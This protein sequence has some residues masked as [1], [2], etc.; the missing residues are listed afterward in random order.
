M[1]VHLYG[2]PLVDGKTVQLDH[3]TQ[4]IEVVIRSC[5]GVG[6]QDLKDLIQRR[7]EVVSIKEIDRTDYVI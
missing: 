6:L 3:S 2:K 4:K 5:S 1:Q 7:H